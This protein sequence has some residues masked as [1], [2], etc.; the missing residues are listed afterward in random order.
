MIYDPRS[1][2]L[3]KNIMDMYE[4]CPE[5]NGSGFMFY[6]CCT[7]EVLGGPWEDIQMCPLCKEHLGEQDCETCHGEKKILI[8]PEN[9][10]YD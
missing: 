3:K 4:K 5:C 6:S 9:N 8:E 10:Y 2:L 7:G 1:F